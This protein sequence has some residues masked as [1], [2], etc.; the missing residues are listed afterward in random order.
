M[1]GRSS[2]EIIIA[3]YYENACRELA[4]VRSV[5][6]VKEILNSAIGMK[7]YAAQA[8]NKQLLI[9]SI[10]VREIATRKIGWCIDQQR[11]TV[12]LSKG[13]REKGTNRGMTRVEKNP[14]SFSEA[15]R[16]V[17]ATTGLSK[18]PVLYPR[19]EL[20]MN[21][22]QPFTEVPRVIRA[23]DRLDEQIKGAKTMSEIEAVIVE[24]KIIQK[25]YFAV[26]EVGDK[27][28]RIWIFA[29]SRLAAELAMI[30]KA[31]GT[32]GQFAGKEAGSG[33]G[34]GKVLAVLKPHRQNETP[35]RAEL[36]ISKKRSALAAKLNE[37]PE[38]RRDRYISELAE[39][40]KPINPNTLV[41]KHRQHNKTEQKRQLLAAVFSAKGPFDVVV[42]D[43]PWNMQ[44]ID[45]DVRPNQD[46]FD[47]PTMTLDEIVEHWQAEI[48][49]KLK[50]NVHTFWWTTEKY[51]PAC[52]AML[53]LLGQKYVLTMVWHKPG[54]FQPIDLPQY[55]AEFIVYARKGAPIFTDTKNFFV[56][57]SWPRSEHSR[58]PK[59][60]YQLIARVTAG[61]RLDVFARE[62]HKG[63]AQYGNETSKFER[64]AAE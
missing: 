22:L 21:K 10:E 12:G 64:D 63:F 48:E 7:A 57:N 9:E 31:K 55:N 14:A 52:I 44:K 54:G 61:S 40:E 60:F 3:G 2:N 58:K 33:K 36:G 17:A 4:K 42:T 37:I 43:P 32:R 24:A 47:Y 16:R 5:I 6:D 13:A 30:G 29:E 28:G 25:R 26:K 45:R 39:E 8:K 49:P 46:A 20:V 1:H 59:E 11:Q 18:N 53:P 41:Q 38:A 23:L 15:D 35:T 51:L 56:C 50:E 62:T 27:A 34:T 19:E